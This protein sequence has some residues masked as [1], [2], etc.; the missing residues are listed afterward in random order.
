MQTVD[1]QLPV[2]VLRNDPEKQG[3]CGSDEEMMM[4]RK[5]NLLRCSDGQV[6]PVRRKR[7]RLPVGRRL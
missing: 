1:C 6:L 5:E 2:E 4:M 3:K 7:S